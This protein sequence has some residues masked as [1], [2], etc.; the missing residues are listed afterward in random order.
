MVNFFHFFLQL[1]YDC[2]IH[3]ICSPDVSANK[4][5]SVLHFVFFWSFSIDN[6]TFSKCTVI[7]VLSRCQDFLQEI[8]GEKK[9]SGKLRV[10]RNQQPQC[11][12]EQNVSPLLCQ[13]EI[14][15]SF[16]TPKQ[17]SY[18]E[19]LKRALKKSGVATDVV[20]LLSDDDD[21]EVNHK[22]KAAPNLPSTTPTSLKMCQT[23][24]IKC[25]DCEKR[26]S[27]QV[28]SIGIQCGESERYNVGVQVV[29]E[30]IDHFRTSKNQSLAHLTPAQLLGRAEPVS[31]RVDNFGSWN[32][33]TEYYHEMGRDYYDDPARDY[34]GRDGNRYPRY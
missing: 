34:Y 32:R 1:T 25:E 3:E 30:D 6:G 28:R 2:E 31:S 33:P 16:N 18:Q 21:N 14:K 11:K 9:L 22:K 27:V 19:I 7:A 15:F 23:D 5:F 24:P 26:K 20:D 29:G 13:K 17:N 12:R 8:T 10:I 4:N